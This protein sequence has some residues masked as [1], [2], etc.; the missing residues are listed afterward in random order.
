MKRKACH[1]CR[2]AGATFA[3]ARCAR[4]AVYSAL[5]LFVLSFILVLTTASAFA[6]SDYS[7]KKEF[8]ATFGFSPGSY[9]GLI[10]VINGQQYYEASLNFGYVLW[11]ND[12]YAFKYKVSLIPFALV[13]GDRATLQL[14]P[15]RTVYAGGA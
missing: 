3:L 12:N 2:Q 5:P 7:Y 1:V 4:T 14:R 9:N 11:R 6:Q 8:G 10:G 13:H 15:D